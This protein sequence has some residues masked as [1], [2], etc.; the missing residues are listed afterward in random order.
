MRSHLTDAKPRTCPLCQLEFTPVRRV[1]K[2]CPR[3]CSCGGR[4]RDSQAARALAEGSLEPRNCRK[5]ERPFVPRARDQVTCGGTCPG[6]PDKE[7]ICANPKCTLPERKFVIKGNSRGKGNQAYCSER[8]RDSFSQWRM[9]ARFRRYGGLTPA[10]FRAKAEAQG[11]LCMICRKE[12]VPDNR[13]RRDGIWAL[14]QD[15]DHLTL[16]L[17]D[18]LCGHCN[19][20]IGHFFDDPELL[21]AAADYIEKHRALSRAAV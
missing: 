19:R 20:G 7:A 1:Q 5:C 3:N 9:R 15:H 2:Y 4:C 21:R 11:S 16:A 6:K 17:R 10:E 12:P 14:E 13:S 8:C 18:L